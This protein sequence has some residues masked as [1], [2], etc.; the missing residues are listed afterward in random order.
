MN[1]PQDEKPPDTEKTTHQDSVKLDLPIEVLVK[2]GDK[3][4]PTMAEWIL[5]GITF[6]LAV[7][8]VFIIK[9]AGDQAKAAIDAVQLGRDQFTRQLKIDFIDSIRQSQRDLAQDRKDALFAKSQTVR[10]SFYFITTKKSLRPYIT[11]VSDT[12]SFSTP[13]IGGGI[14]S[15]NIR[16]KNVGKTPAYNIISVDRYRIT[17]NIRN[18][19]IFKREIKPDDFREITRSLGENESSNMFWEDENRIFTKQDST[20]ITSGKFGIFWGFIFTYSD[21]FGD[22]HTLQC[23]GVNINGGKNPNRGRIIYYK[24]ND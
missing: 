4:R 16:Y 12:F 9:Y 20:D 24:R 18:S 5:I 14:P 13:V 15:T 3:D 21:I 22:R 11:L 1:E 17:N 23:V 7:F 2:K 19:D 6:L 8:N 10:D